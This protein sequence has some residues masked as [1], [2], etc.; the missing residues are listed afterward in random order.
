[1]L[2]KLEAG[3]PV[4]LLVLACGASDVRDDASIVIFCSSDPP[5]ILSRLRNACARER[6]EVLG[7][8]FLTAKFVEI[9]HT[10]IDRISRRCWWHNLDHRFRFCSFN[11]LGDPIHV[12]LR[13]HGQICFVNNKQLLQSS[14]IKER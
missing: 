12:A 3:G 6:S 5:G 7:Q 4:S 14:T 10:N 2:G 13:P 11:T 9:L 8:K 1:M